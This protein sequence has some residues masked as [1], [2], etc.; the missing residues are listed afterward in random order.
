MKLEKIAPLAEIISSFAIVLTL[1]YL[2]IQTQQTNSALVANSRQ[3]TMLADMTLISALIANPEAMGN[4]RRPFNELTGAEQDQLGN[5][6]AGVLRS[7]EFAWLQYQ[8]GILDE[9]TFASYMETPIR[10]IR[11]D[12]A[13]R[14]YWEYFSASANPEFKS[15]VDSLLRVSE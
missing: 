12:E 15:Y 7:R 1:I 6:L 11:E 5:V 10:W 9:A 14:Y 3:A 4:T 8:E 2:A 13:F